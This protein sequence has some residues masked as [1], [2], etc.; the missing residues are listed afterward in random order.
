MLLLLSCSTA[1]NDLARPQPA[2][3][4]GSPT[5]TTTLNTTSQQPSTTVEVTDPFE[6]HIS[7]NGTDDAVGTEPSPVR[8][9]DR[10]LSLVAPGG[11]VIFH[12]GSY[13]PIEIIGRTDLSLR[14][15]EGDEVTIV[16]TGFDRNSGILISDSDGITVDGIDVT[17]VLWGIWI[18]TSSA[19]LVTRCDIYDI[20]QEGVVVK[21]NSDTVDVIENVIR[22]TGLRP[23]EGAVRP[24]SHF[25]EGIYIGNAGPL[26]D[27]SWDRTTGVRVVGNHIYD[28]TA[29][30]VD[31][32]PWA[33]NILIE[34]NLVHDVDTAT[35]GA[36]V[37]S[38]GEVVTDA[39]EVT[40]R[41]NVLHSI[42]RT[43]PYRDG[44]A[45]VASAPASVIGN[46]IWDVE[47]FG[48]LVDRNLATSSSGT[49]L[50]RDN[51]IL[52]AGV[53]PIARHD[54]SGSVPV[55]VLDNELGPGA[56]AFVLDVLGEEFDGLSLADQETRAWLLV[57]ALLSRTES[58]SCC[59][60]TSESKQ[61]EQ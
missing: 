47:H 24:F 37:V 59:A 55:S 26:D 43:S 36:I 27:G 49:L 15:R 32:K 44:N 57:G 45:I 1:A 25:G 7:P 58:D 52:T 14:S 19:V 20:G 2:E 9:F 29:E 53:E 16:G 56:Q 17:Q 38:I 51:V 11:T 42:T 10:A 28:T 30:A 22:S 54:D 61:P 40:I 41:G 5:P 12:G 34:A 60:E 4:P 6:V 35:S 50:V 31:V 48:I 18:E 13:P 21:K 46:V 33:D 8:S 39:A 3:T 23:G